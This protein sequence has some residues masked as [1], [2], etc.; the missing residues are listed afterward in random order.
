LHFLHPFGLHWLGWLRYFACFSQRILQWWPHFLR[1]RKM[2]I[3]LR[4]GYVGH[5]KIWWG[6]GYTT[7]P[8][9]HW[10]TTVVIWWRWNS[11]KWWH[12]IFVAHFL[13]GPWENLLL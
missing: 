2:C 8:W 6:Y 10:Y 5:R 7:P 4:K 11:S 13:L 1:L 9:L 12:I 3:C